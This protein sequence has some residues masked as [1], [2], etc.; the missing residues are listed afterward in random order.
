[1][2]AIKKDKETCGN[3]LGNGKFRLSHGYGQDY[4]FE[5]C[6]A[7]DGTGYAKPKEDKKNEI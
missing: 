6:K 4:T 3:C 1:M 2:K 7:C 5:K